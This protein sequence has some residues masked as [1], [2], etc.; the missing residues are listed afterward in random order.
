MPENVNYVL[1]QIGFGC[2]DPPFSF[3]WAVLKLFTNLSKN[4]IKIIE[5]KFIPNQPRFKVKFC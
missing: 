4:Q 2:L 3:E 5:L 1:D